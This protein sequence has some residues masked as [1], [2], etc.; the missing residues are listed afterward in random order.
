MK[1]AIKRMARYFGFEISR[2]PL[3]PTATAIDLFPNWI[4]Q[5]QKAEPIQVVFDVGANHGQTVA[6]FRSMFPESTIYAFEP[7]LSAYEELQQRTADD[8]KA[9]SFQLALGAHD[10]VATLHENAADVTNSLLPNSSRMY[11]YA[12]EE[13]CLPTGES[14]T[15]II[16]LD[17]FCKNESIG[18]I[19]LLKVDAQGYERHILAGA[20]DYLTPTVIRGLMLEALFVDIYEQ[21]TW[22]GEVLE[23]LRSRGYRLFGFTEVCY[24][25]THGW[26]WADAMFLGDSP[27]DS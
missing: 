27:V 21:Q 3:P 23:L 9:K 22:C 24:D 18:H 2:Y 7:N 11:E 6:R 14:S 17:S 8:P 25:S 1:A 20:G 4:N 12:P 19:D 15:S 26:K 10:G 13:M 16:R 5:L